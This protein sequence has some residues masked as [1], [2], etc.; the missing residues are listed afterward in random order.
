MLVKQDFQGQARGKVRGL[1]V[2]QGISQKVIGRPDEFE[3]IE[4][5][6]QVERAI[7]RQGHGGVVE[8]GHSAEKIDSRSGEKESKRELGSKERAEMARLICQWPRDDASL[9]GRR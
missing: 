5:A 2:C 4:Q 6:C 8:R 9:N 1:S 3:K 7:R